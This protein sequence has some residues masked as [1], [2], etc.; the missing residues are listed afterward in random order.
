MWIACR[1]T[2]TPVILS[3]L[4][5]AAAKAQ[6]R[7]KVEYYSTEQGLSHQRVTNLLKDQEGFMWFGTW[8]GINRFDGRSFVSFKSAPDNKFQIGNERIDQIVEDQAGHLWVSA[9][10]GEVYQFDKRKE[11]FFPITTIIYPGQKEKV[12]FRNILGASDGLVWMRSLEKGLFA[13]S[14]SDL[15]PGHF[16]HY[17]RDAL[18]EYRLPSDTIN[19]FHEDSSH[20]IWVGTSQG[21][22]RLRK[23]ASGIFSNSGIIPAA[24]ATRTNL[25]AFDEDP[26]QLY[27]TTE[28]GRLIIFRKNSGTFS[29]RKLTSGHLYSLCRSKKSDLLFAAGSNGEVLELDLAGSLLTKVKY[30]LPERFNNLFEDRT[31]AL[32]IE[33]EKA[34]AIRFDPA[35]GSFQLF[36]FNGGESLFYIGNRYGVFEDNGGTVWVNMK[37]GGFGFYDPSTKKIEYVMPTPDGADYHLP[38]IVFGAYYDRNGIIW[39]MTNERELVKIVL[40]ENN[41][42]Q[43]LVVKENASPSDNDLRG[44]LYDKENRLWLGAKKGNLYVYRDGKLLKDL[45]I[46]PPSDGLSKVYSILQDRRGNI[47]LGTKDNGLF[48]AT[49]VNREETKYRLTHFLPDQN[50]AAGLPC[51]E[52]YALLEDKQGRIWVGSFDNGLSEI[53]DDG[54]QTN[55]VHGG[56]PFQHYPKRSF[57][58]IRHMALDKD[59]DLWIGTTNG[60]LVQSAN[61]DQTG[62]YQYKTYSTTSPE[63]ERLSNND[64]QFIHRDGKDRMWLATSGG[65]FCL[66]S[67]ARPLTTLQFLNYTTKDGMPSDYFLACAEDNSGNFWLSTENGIAKFNPDTRTTRNYDSYDGL[68]KLAYSEASVCTNVARTE[69]VFGTRHG[70]IS[71]NPDSINTSRIEANLALTNLQINN[72]DVGPGKNSSADKA[73]VLTGD[74]NYMS[75]LTLKHDQNII[76]L[77][78]AILDQRAGNRQ[79]MAY[80][81]VGFD[82]TWHNDRQFRRATYTNLPPGNYTFEVKALSPDLY[83]NQPYRSLSILILP[84]WWATGWAYSLY[85]VA[86]AILFYFIRRNAVD[87]IRLRHK[88]AMEERLAQL[89]MNFFT[90]VSHE[91]RTPLTLI[92][93]PLEQLSRKTNLSPEEAS[94]VET[95]RR[96]ADRT[97]RFVNQLLDLRKAQSDKA[98]LHI[99]RV[100]LVDFVNKVISH[101][102]EATRTRRLSLTITSDRP[103]LFAWVDPEKLDVVIYNL[104]SNA[105][106]FTPEGKAIT[107]SIGTPSEEE[108]FFIKV[109]DQGPGVPAE[110]LEEIFE[111]FREVENAT[112]RELKGT[113]IGLAL[114]REFVKLHEGRIWAENN[115]DGGLTIT[116]ALKVGTEAATTSTSAPV[117]S[118]FQARPVPAATTNQTTQTTQ[119]TQA[120]HDLPLSNPVPEEPA[121]QNEGEGVPLV[122]LV[123]DNEE[124]RSFIEGQLRRYFRVVT[125]RDGEEGLRQAGDLAP[126][127][128]LSDIM[129]PKLD[130]IQMLDRLRKDVNTSHIPVVLLSAKYSIESQIEGL[131]YGADYYITKPFNSDFLLACINNLINQRKKIFETLVAKKQ[132]IGLHVESLANPTPIVITSRDESFLKQVIKVVEERMADS[133]FNIDLVAESLA[134][135]QKTFYR[136]FKS[137]TGHTPVEFVRDIRMQRAKQL[138]DAGGANISEVAYLVGFSN[139]KY[140]STCFREK[141][142]VSPSEY[143]RERSSL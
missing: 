2:I 34:G 78:F 116:V 111:L 80:R 99:S 107:V 29:I 95:A 97:V 142:Q 110:K 118:A 84:P 102:S 94:W 105:I 16:Q 1:H 120:A 122:L 92:V 134:M 17:H 104:L 8:D 33:P 6:P 67:G 72:K 58:K 45:F 83:T 36:S 21:L 3:L 112:S 62:A 131:K 26:E 43:Q 27:F 135:S 121:G 140:F 63:G 132:P 55:F 71:F 18:A 81:L 49:P 117:E 109:Q 98:S 57:Q 113:G 86:A 40:Q 123:E 90:N 19:F 79:A 91:L 23:T 77:D 51:N 64:I 52:I 69:I 88:I 126:D 74:I 41:F 56:D 30:R 24:V 106:K 35:T 38:P 10:D 42:K 96:N 48:K 9:Y 100:E 54:H 47:W 15:S 59:G 61:T 130:G 141:Y 89:K 28:D 70:Y 5:A 119:T 133:E 115:V 12:I 11:V 129:M 136:K 20:Q 44:T 139:P 127:L 137:L 138:L 14:Q 108:L 75:N 143:L 85:L 76:S 37:K 124:L 53:I 25:T 101:F 128:V 7:G 93:G 103:E 13:V 125:A 60:L 114:C 32:W 73:S 65:G 4:F 50:N 68:A 82:S 22:C 39:L 87:K 66:S 46:N 31:G